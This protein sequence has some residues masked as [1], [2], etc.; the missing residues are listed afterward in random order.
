M[1]AGAE[2]IIVT[3]SGCGV[4]LKEYGY[5]MRD[6][7]RY[8]EDAQ[9]VS[10]LTLDL[11]EVLAK[12]NLST[13]ALADQA[14][15]ALHCPCTLT[16][17]SRQSETLRAVL[18]RLGVRMTATRENHICC[19]SAGTYSIIQ[20][21]M[22]NQLLER[23]IQALS[24]DQPDRIVTA[25]IGCQLHLASKADVPVSHWIELLDP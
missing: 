15:T 25:N 13:I 16:H 6:D 11:C 9:A 3:S 8:A 4:M 20:P 12:E 7:P 21:N 17:G 19:G 10:N 24:E 1:Q 5:I 14:K 22:S 2:G 23:K 18:T